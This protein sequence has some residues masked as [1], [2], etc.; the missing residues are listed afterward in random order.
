MEDHLQKFVSPPAVKWIR[1]SYPRFVNR[2]ISGAM[3][4]RQPFGGFR[5]SGAGSKTGGSVAHLGL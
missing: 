2:G 5:M 3:V 1:P 4:G